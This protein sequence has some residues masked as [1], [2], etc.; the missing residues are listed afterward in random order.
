MTDIE[1]EATFYKKNPYAAL[2]V[3]PRVSA[4]ELKS[5]YR[6]LV[7]K[8]HPDAGGD[9]ESIRSESY[10]SYEEGAGEES[11]QSLAALIQEAEEV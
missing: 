9:E 5:A 10:R 6:A 7:K 2:G 4:S 1:R 8:H 3:N 11:G